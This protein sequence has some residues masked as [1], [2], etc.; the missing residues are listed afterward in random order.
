L[1]KESEKIEE[2]LENEDEEGKKSYLWKI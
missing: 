1:K 2:E